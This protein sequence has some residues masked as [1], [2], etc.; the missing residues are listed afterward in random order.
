MQAFEARSVD[1]GFGFVVEGGNDG[2][3][4]FVVVQ[5]PDAFASAFCDVD[6]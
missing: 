5:A 1:I 4:G 6:V 3:D 2:F